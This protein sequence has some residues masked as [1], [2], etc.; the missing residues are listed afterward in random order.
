MT[1][2]ERLAQY[3]GSLRQ[4]D[5]EMVVQ[6]VDPNDNAARRFQYRR[7]ASTLER[8]VLQSD[9]TPFS[10]G[11]EWQPLAP[12]ELQAL[13]AVRGQWHPILDP[14]GFRG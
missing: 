8:R 2:A 10:D 5:G 11:S 6:L 1:T 13:L 12:H 3:G 9:G 14:L 4:V 7:A